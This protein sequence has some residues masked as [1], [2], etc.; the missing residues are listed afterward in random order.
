MLLVDR[1]RRQGQYQN[2]ADKEGSGQ[3]IHTH[4]C[5]PGKILD[6][7]YHVR[8]G[9]SRQI[10][11]RINES[12]AG[13]SRSSPEEGCGQAPEQGQRGYD[14]KCSESESCHGNYGI[15]G[16]KGTDNQPRSS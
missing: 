3:R 11:Y 4:A 8:A 14:S 7:S 12:Y 1:S 10:A 13:S 9:K 6:P 2:G 16:I 5:A 15:A